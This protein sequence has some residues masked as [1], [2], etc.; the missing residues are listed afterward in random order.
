MKQEKKP[1]KGIDVGTLLAEKRYA[2][3]LQELQRRERDGSAGPEDFY[4]LGVLHEDF[5]MG[6]PNDK[7][8]AEAYYRKAWDGGYVKAGYRLAGIGCGDAWYDAFPEREEIL[9]QTARMGDAG[10]EFVIKMREIDKKFAGRE[11]EVE[12]RTEATKAAC[13]EILERDEDCAIARKILAFYELYG[14]SP[15]ERYLGFH[16]L[17]KL[18][19]H[20]DTDIAEIALEDIGECWRDG[21]Y[22]HQDLKEA[23]KCFRRIL[24]MGKEDKSESA[25]EFLSGKWREVPEGGRAE[26]RAEKAAECVRKIIDAFFRAGFDW[27]FAETDADALRAAENFSAEAACGFVGTEIRA[28]AE[29]WEKEFGEA[30]VASKIEAACREELAEVGNAFE[31]WGNALKSL[32][33]ELG[34]G[35]A[36]PEGDDWRSRPASRFFSA[37]AE[38]G[39][40][41]DA[42]EDALLDAFADVLTNLLDAYDHQ[43][44]DPE[45]AVQP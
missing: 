6:M 44:A 7:D 16:T 15:E 1:G 34:G 30:G 18:A 39:A 38:A 36:E 33:P 40:R 11:D 5:G 32:A 29:F 8:K 26:W 14:R 10:A 43:C 19:D 9:R 23:E 45:N 35:N 31:A 20:W 28:A 24:E 41:L 13:F 4:Y 42:A 3:A 12:R 17:L 37:T 27:N 22:V 2:D 21:R 25:V